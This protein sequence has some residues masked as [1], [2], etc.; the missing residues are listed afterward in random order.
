MRL[1]LLSILISGMPMNLNL[2]ND[3]DVLHYLVKHPKTESSE[4][5]LLILLH[6]V[7]S[8]EKDLFSFASQIPDNFLVISARAPFELGDGRYAW[9]EVDFSSGKPVVNNDKAEQSRK[10]II[11][12]IAQLKEKY[13]FDSKQI[14]L[15]GFSQGAIMSYSVGL[16]RPDLIKGIAVMSGRVLEEIKPLVK[17]NEQLKQLKVFVSHGTSDAVL[18]IHYARESVSY[19]KELGIVPKYK[20]YPEGHT[21]SQEMLKDFLTWLGKK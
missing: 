16:T 17:T 6:G 2:K 18:G 4:T 15:C 13:Q 9:Y 1:V 10:T 20:E 21:I 5:P 19:L 11:Q 8:N 12:F 3:K 14:Y 7:G